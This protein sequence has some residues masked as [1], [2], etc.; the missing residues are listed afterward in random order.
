MSHL[1]HHYKI[2]RLKFWKYSFFSKT[3]LNSQT[4]KILSEVK[5]SRIAAIYFWHS[6]YDIILLL[7][8]KLYFVISGQAA[9]VH[10]TTEVRPD[11]IYT[12]MNYKIQGGQS[13]R[14]PDSS[15]AAKGHKQQ[16]QKQVREEQFI[17]IALWLFKQISSHSVMSEKKSFGSMEIFV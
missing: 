8:N 7:G 16:Q 2:K 13:V 17:G 15:N 9:T 6:V 5:F 12:L 3:K 10:K 4:F 14:K 1:E 11:R